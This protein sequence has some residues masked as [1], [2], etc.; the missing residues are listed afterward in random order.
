MKVSVSTVAA[1]WACTSS[2]AVAAAADTTDEGNAIVSLED[3]S[4]P[5]H[6]WTE[7]SDPVMGGKSSGS[8]HV[9]DGVGH[10]VGRV[11]IVPFL[12]APGFIKMETETE[13]GTGTGAT[14]SSWPDVSSCQGLQL[15]LKSATDYSGYRIGFG[16]ARPPDAF[17]YARGYK[18]DLNLDDTSAGDGDSDGDGFGT[19]RLPFQAFTDKWDAATGDAMVTCEEDSEYCPDAAALKNLSPLSVWGEGVEGD[20]HLEMKTIAAY[21]CNISGSHGAVSS[22]DDN[23][24]DGNSEG[25]EIAIEDFAN[26]INTWET[27]NDPVM[28]GKS[29]SSVKIEDGAAHFSGTCAIVPSLQAPGFIT[30]VTGGYHQGPAVFPDI[31]KCTSLKV[32][33]RTTVR[34]KGY[35]LSFGTDKVPGGH[36]AMGYK[37]SFNGAPYGEDFG[38]VIIPFSDFSS[39]WNEATGKTE[40]K[41]SDDPSFCPSME[42][43]QDMQTMSFWGEGVEGNVALDIKFISA[44]GCS[45]KLSSPLLTYGIPATVVADRLGKESQSPSISN[46]TAFIA[47][48]CVTLAF[49]LGAHVG[50]NIRAKKRS[51]YDEIQLKHTD[52]EM[53]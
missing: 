42:N 7:M 8:F 32:I 6:Q 9:K 53:S 3:F 34:Y 13:T 25:D 45:S 19:V 46:L 14:G 10:F 33:A 15:T 11:E 37:A 50:L 21:G 18:T 51:S 52:A 47:G 38:E 5:K 36:H 40:V 43:L 49:V 26:A 41:C 17:K 29:S 44:V 23:I 1:A 16:T 2:L 20:V 28:G 12:K 27:L 22:R 39:K 4:D 35:Y 24:R 48:A 30:M 31:S